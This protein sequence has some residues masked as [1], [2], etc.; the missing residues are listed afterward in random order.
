MKR[1]GFFDR[2][3][4]ECDSFFDGIIDV[5][6]H[7]VDPDEFNDK[8]S[9]GEQYTY[10]VLCQLFPKNRVFR[11]VY[12]SKSNGRLTEIDLI[13]IS[14]KGVFVFESKNYSGWIF[15]NSTNRYWT[16]FLPNSM[17]NRFYSPILQN[18]GHVKALREKLDAFPQANYHSLI[19]FSKHCELKKITNTKPD[20]YVLKRPELRFYL[21]Q[22][23]KN[24]P[25]GVLAPEEVERIAAWLKA[26]ER[27]DKKLKDRHLAELKAGNK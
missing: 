6:D 23:M 24:A 15:G 1:P 9:S 11:N 17:K 10:N 26:C 27:P 16:Q 20:T 13:A 25:R 12:I 8:G 22:I 21:K 4:I 5:V 2:I 7:L 19:V 14:E 3:R 18:I